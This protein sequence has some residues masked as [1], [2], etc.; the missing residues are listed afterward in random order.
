MT[1]P[2]V[3]EVEVRSQ[4]LATLNLFLSDPLYDLARE[5][6]FTTYFY[7]KKSYGGRCKKAT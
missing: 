4:E 3:Q 7:F 6:A 1:H 5:A 2:T